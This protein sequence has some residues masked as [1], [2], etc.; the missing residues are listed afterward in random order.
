MNKQMKKTALLSIILLLSTI[1]SFA[2]EQ[3]PDLLI[4]GNDTVYLKSFPLEQ[5]RLKEKFKES[6]FDYYE[7]FD[8][9]HT[10]CYRGYIATWKIMDNKLFL[11]EIEKVDSTN[12]KLDIKDYFKKNNYKPNLINGHVFADWYSDT[13]K[14]YDYFWCHFNPK[15]YY[16][17]VDY[18]N[19]PKKK[20]ELIFNNGI[21]TYNNIVKIDSYKEGDTLTKEISY[22]RQWFLKRGLTNIVA[23]IK[24][25]NGI[26]VL[27]EIVD[28]GTRKKR[29]IRSIKKMIGIKEENKQWINPRYWE[30]K[31]K[32]NTL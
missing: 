5:L 30:D 17:A 29:A 14:Q 15:R 9:P 28:F 11:I 32:N 13:L 23:V 7:N 12:L 19:N 3:I 1:Y 8:F 18:L 21:L 20:K 10:A 6:P 27:V 22:Y 24:E 2:T 16:L 26:M 25:N 4:I 31:N